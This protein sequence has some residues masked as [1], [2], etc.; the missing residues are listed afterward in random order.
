MNLVEVVKFIHFLIDII[1]TTYIF[2]FSPI[3]DIYYS[4][5]LLIQTLHWASLKNEC[6]ITYIEK[7]L[8]DPTYEL[9]SDIKYQP[10]T[11]TYYNEITLFMKAI[12]IIGTLTVIIYRTKNKYAKIF[13]AL[14][15]VLW[16]YLTYFY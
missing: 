14:A 4:G 5:F 7:L 13:A 11:E 3:Y 8:L 10:H 1:L 9:G 2:I 15:I 12:L 6:I 16:I